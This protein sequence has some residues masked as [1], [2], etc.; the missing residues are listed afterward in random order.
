[1]PSRSPATALSQ[2]LDART[3]LRTPSLLVGLV[4]AL[5]PGLD[6]AGIT[7]FFGLTVLEAAGVSALGGALAGAWTA[8]PRART[9]AVGALMALGSTLGMLGYIALRTHVLDTGSLFRLEVALGALLG[10]VPGYLLMRHWFGERIDTWTGA[11]PP[12]AAPD[13]ARSVRA[14]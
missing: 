2:R 6:A 3:V 9:A 14:R 4:F 5:L 11:A 10:F 1:M 12:R 13:A 7:P 8:A